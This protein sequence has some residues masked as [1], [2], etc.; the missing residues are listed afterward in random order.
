MTETASSAA[1][2]ELLVVRLA[3]LSGTL[4]RAF[5]PADGDLEGLVV[6]LADPGNAEQTVHWGRNYLYR[7]G[8]ESKA[9]PV[10][11][12]VKQFNNRGLKA[13][14]LRRLRGSKAA[15]SWRIALAFERAGLATAPPVCL[16]ESRRE[17]GPS[18][19]VTRH[20][21]D[22]VEARYLFRA[23]NA[24]RASEE[25][26]WID[27]P[28]F[29]DELGA[30]L[31]RMHAAG[32][33]HR[34]LSIG[35]VLISREDPKRLFVID[36]NRARLRRRLRLGERNRDLCRLAI[37]R[38]ADQKRF[39][40]AYWG[41]PPGAVRTA[42][43]KLYHHG[44]LF[45]IES[46]KRWRRATKRLRDLLRPR[47]AH[48]H[49]PE[50]PAGASSRDK[51][52]W[53]HLSDQPHQHASRLSKTM[54]RLADLPAHTLQT[55]H[56]AAA[57]PGIWRRYKK[58]TN[59]LYRAP[60]PWDGVG[61][62]VR[63]HPEAPEEL[64]EAIEDLGVKKVLLRLH[65]WA[66]DDRDELALARE[67]HELGYELAFSL[68][69]NR[70]L[71]RDPQRWRERTTELAELFVPYGRH[72]QVGQAINRSKWG[73]WT[74]GEYAELARIAT[75]TLRRHEGV[76]VLGPAVIDFEYHATVA[77][78]RLCSQLGFDAVASL[79]YVDRRGAPENPQLGFDTV[80]KVVLLQAIAEKMPGV[81]PRSWVTEVNWPLWEGP[82]S[83][84]GRSV[85]VSE[86]DQADYLARYYLLALTTGMV[87]R[88]YWWQMIA[89]GYGLVAPRDGETPL[90]RRL[91]FQALATLD[92]ELRGARFERRLSAPAGA[93][94]FSFGLASGGECVVG[95]S[96]QGRCRAS[97]PRRAAHVVDQQGESGNA[98]GPEVELGSSVRYFHL[99]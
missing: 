10:D 22:V 39:L 70:E 56:F 98:C 95:W 49:I 12:V 82:H 86:D 37:F 66:D 47:R 61:V 30:T 78:L 3:E 89:R 77:A 79:L 93:Y 69:Q 64:L 50:A 46:K 57:L 4:V 36:L 44:F 13:R 92:R 41:G 90:R 97:L 21:G 80:G 34:D 5:E 32:L 2:V 15:R 43:Y 76:E 23:A 16:I 75:E 42:L 91:S 59:E 84:A 65:P 25:F 58:L 96:S 40:E 33:F 94:L 19:F 1:E 38:P 99:E 60:V 27:Y 72:F 88:V 29:L 8:F 53:D 6:R 28:A 31:A 24:G 18:F 45:K 55:A 14:T 35:N 51:I 85:S 67:L 26:P 71:V 81:G 68:P 17:D 20:L 7:T 48:A 54:I 52:V 62:C 63:P 83:P 74:L 87:E 11:V 9:G 73:I